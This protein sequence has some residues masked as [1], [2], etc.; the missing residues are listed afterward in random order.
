MLHTL[1]GDLTGG[2]S[3]ELGLHRTLQDGNRDRETIKEVGSICLKGNSGIFKPRPYFWQEIRS[4][5][6]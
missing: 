2:H 4:S 1:P 5:T 6:H 3:S